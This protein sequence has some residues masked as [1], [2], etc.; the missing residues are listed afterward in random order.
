HLGGN[1]EVARALT[2][3]FPAETDV[4]QNGA[5]VGASIAVKRVERN[6]S[7]EQTCACTRDAAADEVSFRNQRAA[8]PPVN[9]RSDFSESKIEPGQI[10][11]G[12]GRPHRSQYRVVILG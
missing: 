1:V 7:G 11:R 6:E 9:R 12:F 8:D 2:F 3:A 5:F 10:R 4:L